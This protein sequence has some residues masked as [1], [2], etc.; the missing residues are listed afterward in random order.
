LVEVLE[1]IRLRGGQ[2]DQQSASK[3]RL[4]AHGSGWD[5]GK[6]EGKTREGASAQQNGDH[7]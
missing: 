1:E 6:R 7:M 5:E 2:G 4:A 3:N